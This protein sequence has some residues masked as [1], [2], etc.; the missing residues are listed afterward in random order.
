M[1]THR[2]PARKRLPRGFT[3]LLCLALAGGL[4]L[5][6]A[7]G[8][9][10]AAVPGRPA[11]ELRV[12]CSVFPIYE[13]TRQVAA[14]RPGVRVD[15]MLPPAL[16]C[17][18]DYLL[19]PQDMEK[20]ARADVF[21]ANGLGLEEFLGAPLT[22]ANPRITVID[23]SRGI[24]DLI[25]ETEHDRGAGEKPPASAGAEPHAR[26]NP[27]IFASP[28]LAARMV[29]TIA[30]GLAQAD[31]AGAPL[32]AQNAAVQGGRLGE[33]ARDFAVTVKGLRARRIVTTH[34]VFDY[35]ARASG[36][37]VVAVLEETPGQEPAAAKMIELVRAIKA[38]GAAA[39]FTEPQYPSAVGRTIARE[40][41]VPVAVLDPVASGPEN[42]PPDYY[43]TAMRKNLETLKQTLGGRE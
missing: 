16:G 33:L 29:A 37:D 38:S 12:L 15:L 31:P 14:G 13:F 1:N 21:V 39:V 36:L 23:A 17:P 34:G 42:A 24:T 2:P 7:C 5:T 27:H 26:M 35:L 25:P 18:H 19:T 28:A 9:R 41:G 20:I 43:E 11:E 3:L 8:G 40:V 22:R 32:Y 6:P 30:A 4:L 10:K